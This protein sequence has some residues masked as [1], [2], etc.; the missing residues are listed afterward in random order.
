M[1]PLILCVLLTALAA[2]APAALAQQDAPSTPQ[3]AFTRLEQ[4][5]LIS[6]TPVQN[7]HHYQVL[8]AASPASPCTL[9]EGGRS[10][11]VPLTFSATSLSFLHPDPPSPLVEARYFVS[12]CSA[13]NLC[14]PLSQAVYRDTSPAPLP[15]SSVSWHM[16]QDDAQ[17]EWQEHQD[18]AHYRVNW[19]PYRSVNCNLSQCLLLE[20]RLKSR[21]Y[22]H[23]PAN[24]RDSHL[25]N[26]YWISACN[27]GGCSPAVR[28]T[29]TDLRPAHA[30][31]ITAV[32]RNED[33]SILISWNPV[34]DAVHYRLYHLPVRAGAC[35]LDSRGNPSPC[36]LLAQD[37]VS[38]RHVH[39]EADPLA[40]RYWLAACNAAGCAGPSG[41]GRG[42]EAQPAPSAEPPPVAPATEPNGEPGPA[43][44]QL[45]R[46]T[47]YTSEQVL[48]TL[49][50][51]NHNPVHTLHAEL[52]VHAPDGWAVSAFQ[53]GATCVTSLCRTAR[54]TPPGHTVNATA[55]LTPNSPGRR[56]VA[57]TA[58][59]RTPDGTEHVQQLN[60]AVNVIAHAPA[61]Q[62]QPPSQP[63][64]P[65]AAGSCNPSLQAN[66]A[67]P[68][69]LAL[70]LAT[71]FA[72]K[73]LRTNSAQRYVPA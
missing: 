25:E 11:C 64:P 54:S 24:A 62:P 43:A 45:S 67:S 65:E 18:A 57:A 29:F 46:T 63:E 66:D 15:A 19:T 3:A 27:P 5:A 70:I 7:A 16:N 60:A 39:Q 2:A 47:V 17:I 14:S 41:P 59:W 38:T 31:E 37:L 10:H 56:T 9:G 26:H 58:R 69:L 32:R 30:P 8:L 21:N 61:A 73:T 20:K 36:R 35:R 68:T 23:R 40:N 1:K 28:A 22:R 50:F 33:G 52:T 48:A 6:W 42:H 12:A 34:P 71:A 4:D 72:L 49:T 51:T 53:Q 55:T 13:D 44:L